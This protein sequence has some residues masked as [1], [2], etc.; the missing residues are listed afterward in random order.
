[1]P[2]SWLGRALGW[3]VHTVEGAQHLHHLVDPGGVL[4]LILDLADRAQVSFPGTK[5]QRGHREES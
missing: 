2:V 1:M 4:R 5:S 3:T